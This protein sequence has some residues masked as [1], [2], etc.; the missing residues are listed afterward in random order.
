[1]LIQPVIILNSKQ[2]QAEN[3][4]LPVLVIFTLTLAFLKQYKVTGCL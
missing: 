1:M 3:A 4:F 2:I